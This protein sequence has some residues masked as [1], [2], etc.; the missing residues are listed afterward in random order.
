MTILLYA[1]LITSH[2]M[3][4]GSNSGSHL[5]K[6]QLT[7]KTELRS[8]SNSRWDLSEVNN[9]VCSHSTEVAP[10]TPNINPLTFSLFPSPFS[11][12]LFFAFPYILRELL[13]FPFDF[14]HP[15]Y[16]LSLRVNRKKIRSCPFD[17]VTLTVISPRRA[18]APSCARLL[19]TCL[20]SASS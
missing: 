17:D 3:I 11:L 8:Q 7:K 13:N 18:T 4:S 2:V 1:I 9:D 6:K 5:R 15:S 20:V 16:H 10:T 12:L 14:L 19:H